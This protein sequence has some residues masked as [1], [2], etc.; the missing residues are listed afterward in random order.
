MGKE[1]AKVVRNSDN[2]ILRPKPV[3]GSAE[4]I[5]RAG[6]KEAAAYIPTARE[7]VQ[8]VKYWYRRRLEDMWCYFCYGQS[9]NDMSATLCCAD[10]RISLAAEVIGWEAVHQAIVEV[11]EEFRAEVRPRPALDARLWDIFENGTPEQWEAVQDES[12]REIFEQY[13]AGA[14]TK[15]EQLQKESPSDFVALVLHADLEEGRRPVLVSPTDSE[16]N[17]VLRVMGNFEMETD[18][19]KVR[20]LM[21]DQ[22]LSSA[23]FIRGA[24]HENGDWRFEFPDSEP[25]TV[26]WDFL[27]RVTGQ[28]RKLLHAGKASQ[29]A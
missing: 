28:I 1:A 9:G 25:G 14:L 22:K 18:V 17:A 7:L 10:F 3:T 20:T 29:P 16:L 12:W 27:E 11:R 4:Q 15:L 26:G 23:G 5:G 13:A 2:E 6:A 21:V 19:S 8:L 24:R